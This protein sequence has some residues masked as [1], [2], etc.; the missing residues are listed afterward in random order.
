MGLTS[1][2]I[3]DYN[4]LNAFSMERSIAR[5]AGASPISP[6]VDETQNNLKIHSFEESLN[7]L[8]GSQSRLD[9]IRQNIT[10]MQEIVEE[11]NG[12]NVSLRKQEEYFGKLRSL[13]AG[14]D[15]IVEQTFFKEASF[16]NGRSV[17]LVEGSSSTSTTTLDFS[18]LYTFGEDSLGLSE[19]KAS[20]ETGVSYSFATMLHNQSSGLVGLD[21]ASTE[22]TS[23]AMGQL[24]LE[25]GDYQ[26]E[27]LYQGPDSTIIL[28]DLDG[29]EKVRKEG[30]D[31]GGDGQEIIDMGVGFKLFV[32]KENPFGE[33]L[34]KYDYENLGSTS[35]KAD[36]NYKR[37]FQHLLHSEEGSVTETTAVLQ[38]SVPAKD[39]NNQLKVSSIAS[40]SVSSGFKE[41]ETGQYLVEV[42]YHGK[43]SR[44]RLLDA[45]GGLLGL[46]FVDLEQ[47]D[48]HNFNLGVGVVLDIE[49]LNFSQ[50]GAITTVSFDYQKSTQN[51][52]DFDYKSFQNRLDAAADQVDSLATLVSDTLTKFQEDEQ[53]KQELLSGNGSSSNNLLFGGASAVSLLSAQMDPGA[54]GLFGSYLPSTVTQAS[55]DQL[56]LSTHSMIEA[57]INLKFSSVQALL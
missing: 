42:V 21:I 40:N 25:T 6:E 36:F 22:A 7:F 17:V 34:D 4:N 54:A 32:E 38:N 19:K 48:T 23:V 46:H 5:L 51:A 18:N 29:E 45:E 55:S 8:A 3:S 10:T 27:F 33:D 37:N 52:Q 35:L 44:V 15:Q 47:S 13:S 53:L 1:T 39:G 2:E 28:R 56:F 9:M 49:N 11:A 24:E 20:A 41:L 26:I 14:L 12:R 31:L 43:D 50:E 30:V 16:M 57:Q